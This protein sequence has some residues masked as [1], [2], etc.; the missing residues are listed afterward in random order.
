MNDKITYPKNILRSHKD[1]I[2]IFFYV[3]IH[4]YI[5]ITSK[6]MNPTVNITN[7]FI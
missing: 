1:Y 6:F 4:T 5:L 3:K 2:L 7:F